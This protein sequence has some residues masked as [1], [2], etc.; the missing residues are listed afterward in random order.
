MHWFFMLKFR[1]HLRICPQ[2]TYLV[3]PFHWHYRKWNYVNNLSIVSFSYYWKVPSPS[4]RSLAKSPSYLSP[5]LYFKTP[6]PCILLSL[7]S[8]SYVLFQS[9]RSPI[10]KIS[11]LM[12]IHS[13]EIV[14][15][16][17][18]LVIDILRTVSILFAIEPLP[19]VVCLILNLE[20]PVT[21]VFG[22][23]KF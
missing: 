19:T 4:K 11:Q 12:T 14:V 15:K 13:L 3:V 17:E 8:P 20:S 18:R 23:Q 1:W 21:I 9:L 22:K 16:A 2:S 10:S 7:C 6:L 5:F